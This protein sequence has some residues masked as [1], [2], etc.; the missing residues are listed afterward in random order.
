VLV[1]GITLLANGSFTTAGT[2][3]LVPETSVEYSLAQVALHK[4]AGS[5][6]TVVRGSVYDLTLWVSQHPGGREA[7]VGMC[8]KDATVGFEAQHGEQR[9]PESELRSFQ[10]GT[11]KI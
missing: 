4:D 7:I 1:L 3:V 8:G 11:L 5:C 9:K 2:A 6:W 10:I